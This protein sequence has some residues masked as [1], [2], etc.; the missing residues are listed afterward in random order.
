[1][2]S[3][4]N[5]IQSVGKE[6]ELAFPDRFI[7]DASSIHVVVKLYKGYD[8]VVKPIFIDERILY[9]TMLRLNDKIIQEKWY[10]Y[11]KKYKIFHSRE[12]L[13]QEI[14]LLAKHTKITTIFASDV[15]LDL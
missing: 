15:V 9:S 1:M 14:C 5:E 6:L 4:E 10:G 11:D 7:N 13:I 12:K 2:A 8:V 3:M